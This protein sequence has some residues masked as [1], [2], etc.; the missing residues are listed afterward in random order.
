MCAGRVGR[1]GMGERGTC[2]D[3]AFS[4]PI[5]KLEAQVARGPINLS[6]YSSPGEIK[7]LP[8]FRVS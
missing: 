8:P 6:I 2:D 3:T 1:V 5:Q 7:D 4:F